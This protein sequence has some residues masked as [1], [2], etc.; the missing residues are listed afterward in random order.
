MKRFSYIM[1][2]VLMLTLFAG[3]LPA[4]VSADTAPQVI[5]LSST[6]DGDTYIHTA[7]LNGTAGPEYDYTWHV[8]PTTAHDEVKD[9]P[10]EDHTGAKP[11]GE[12]VYIAH[13]IYYY[14]LLDQDKF[15]KVTYDGETEWVYPYE[16]A[17]YENYLFSTLPVLK[18]GFPSQMMHTASEAY[19]NAVLHIT[20]AGVYQLEGNWHGQI[21]VDLGDDAFDDP[22]QTVTLILNGVTIDCTVASG[23][24]FGSVYECDND[25]EDADEHSHIVDTTTAGARI[26]LADGTSNAVSGTNIFRILKT[27]YKDDDSTD[28]YPAQ[29]KRLKMDGAVYS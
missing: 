12:A 22:T 27:K 18:T 21:R 2:L 28:A 20:Q 26:V 23:I 15:Q 8:D 17:G 10:A 25:W 29:K 24:V 6:A 19:Q 7:T 3:V 14:P 5:R 13:D 11:N 1:A 9:S 16:A 4:T